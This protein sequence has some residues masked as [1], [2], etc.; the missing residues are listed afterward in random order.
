[1][2]RDE[3]VVL[4]TR[5]SPLVIACVALAAL[6]LLAVVLVVGREW[7]LQR[8]CP[9]EYYVGQ[10][11]AQPGHGSSLEFEGLQTRFL[12]NPVLDKVIALGPESTCP[13]VE[14]L[15]SGSLDI[16]QVIV[17]DLVLWCHVTGLPKQQVPVLGQDRLISD[18]DY[19][20][21]TKAWGVWDEGGRPTAE[22]TGIAVPVLQDY[23]R[24]SEMLRLLDGSRP[25][26]L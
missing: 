15:Q 12:R 17:F 13:L 6:S 25:S 10:L 26:Q 19:A 20:R 22:A 14:R 21:V 23:P 9:G 18:A 2:C 5:R 24:Y 11:A 3:R 4:H 16:G 1:M 7:Y 8:F